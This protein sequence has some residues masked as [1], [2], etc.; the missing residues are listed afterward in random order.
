MGV[1]PVPVSD[2][3]TRTAASSVSRTSAVRVP[4]LL[5]AFSELSPMFQKTCRILSA[6]AQIV[7]GCLGQPPFHTE[8]GVETRIVLQQEQ[9]FI[10]KSDQ[11]FTSR[12]SKPLF[13]R[14]GQ[15]VADQFVQSLRFAADNTDE[16]SL[17]LVQ[18]TD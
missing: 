18:A 3:M 14:V 4:P 15:E 9:C 12:K 11:S 7:T 8:A 1:N 13:A 2:K 10:Q 16:L 5:I 6:S 17:I